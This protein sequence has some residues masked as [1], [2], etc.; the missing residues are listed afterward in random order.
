MAYDL[1][2]QESLDELKAWWEKWGNVTLTAITAVCLAFAGYNGM[3][4]YDRH[5]AENASLA[6]SS[7]Q[8]AI[9]GQQEVASVDKIVH[10]LIED[11]GSTV[12]GPMGALSAAK[13]F[14]TKGES[15][16][17]ETLLQWVVNESKHAEYQ[18]VARLRLAG[19]QLDQKK[20]DEAI[21][22]LKAAKPTDKQVALIQDRL[23]DVYFA[24]N[25]LKAARSAWEEAVKHPLEPSLMGFV[26]LKLQALP[27]AK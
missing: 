25:D 10:A 13:Y 23:G 2:E 3:K 5:Q 27:E 17:A 22:N 12:Y 19:F 26:Q 16:K 1:Q 20:Y 4:W 21:A 24:K 18:T 11:A 6:Y 7:L 8:S 15:A 14:E 9:A